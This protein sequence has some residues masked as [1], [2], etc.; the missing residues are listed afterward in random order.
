MLLLIRLGDRSR[1]GSLGTK[2]KK[3]TQ[4]KSSKSKL[5]RTMPV[6]PG[7][8]H[9]TLGINEC[10]NEQQSV[11]SDLLG[12]VKQARREQKRHREGVS[13]M[14][15]EVLESH[16]RE[17]KRVS[18]E[19]ESRVADLVQTYKDSKLQLKSRDKQ[20]EGLETELEYRLKK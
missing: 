1:S 20:L 17:L 11:L 5:P 7:F 2:S 8:S 12:R 14:Q 13:S 18:R 9:S 4:R 3:S 15:R 10:S 16:D 19:L 6:S